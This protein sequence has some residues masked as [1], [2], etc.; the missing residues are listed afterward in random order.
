M[1]RVELTHA[2]ERRQSEEGWGSVI[3]GKRGFRGRGG[4]LWAKVARTRGRDGMGW[5]V[6]R[7]ARAKESWGPSACVIEREHEEL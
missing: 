2:W 1:I 7:L 4:G 5:R 3:Q 6:V